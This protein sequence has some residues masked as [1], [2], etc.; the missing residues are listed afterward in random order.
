MKNSVEPSS[1][2]ILPQDLDAERA[3]VGGLMLDNQAAGAALAVLSS[4][5]R[6]FYRT[7]H[8]LIFRAV[9]GL[10][11]KGCV[12]DL[13]TV[14]DELRKRGDLDRAGGP[15]YVSDV[16]DSAISAATIGHYAEIVKSKAI[17]RHIIAEAS[18]LIEAAYDP[19]K[20]TTEV[21][22]E[23]Q[24]T[25]LNLSAAKEKKTLQGARDVA[26]KTFAM[27][28]KRHHQGGMMTGLSSGIHDLD[29][30]ILGLN[31][32]D[33]IIVAARPGM[34]KT[35]LAGNIALHVALEGT[36]ALMISLEMPAES[37]MT[38]CLAKMSGIDSRQLR[39]GLVKDSQ[40]SRLVD[41]TGRIG[42]A[43]LFI[44]DNPDIAPAE[45]RAKT[46]RLKA[47]YGLGLLVVDYMQLMR[48]PG[49]HE[50]REQAVAEISRT[51]KAIARELEIPV[52]GLSQLNRQVDNRPDKRPMLSDL[53]ESG[54]IEQDAD[55]IVF[56]YRDEVYDKRPENPH[57]G[58]AE[59]EIAKH[60]NGPTGTLKMHF[61]ATTQTFTDLYDSDQS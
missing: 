12:A 51:L 59:I 54:A 10:I 5:G 44:D 32:G 4:D 17:E 43:P 45:I 36:T 61:E 27:I 20:E 6:D 40:W 48:V 35:A 38:R 57:R 49:R 47:E 9:L 55:I 39:R 41:A 22:N 28:E 13:I 58:I 34:G 30:L 26:R 46:R 19:A 1:G 31:A 60:R 24:S 23:V 2:R 15:V 8:R 52:I 33:L 18:R 50:T 56:I 25:I 21:L 7:G 3:V 37:L 16:S 53:R 29:T 42:G 14:C 11:D